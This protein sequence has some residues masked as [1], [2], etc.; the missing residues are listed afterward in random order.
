MGTQRGREGRAGWRGL[1]AL[2]VLLLGLLGGALGLAAESPDD[3]PFG[4]V[5]YHQMV[6]MRDA[7]KLAT[8]VYLPKGPGPFPTLL[9]RDIYGNGSAPG[10]QRYASWATENGYALVFQNARGRYDSEGQW[11]PYF[12]EINDGY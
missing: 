6:P 7:V 12:Q 4:T 2:G 10:R 1:C 9:V 11:T 8:D 5:R 3:S